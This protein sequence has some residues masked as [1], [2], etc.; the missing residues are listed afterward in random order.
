MGGVAEVSFSPPAQRVMSNLVFLSAR[1]HAYK[2]YAEA[3]S[4]HLFRRLQKMGTLHCMPTL[5]PGRMSSSA[6]AMLGGAVMLF[7]RF[8][9]TCL[10]IFFLAAFAIYRS[11]VHPITVISMLLLSAYVYG[12]FSTRRHRNA[13]EVWRPVG[14]DKVSNFLQYRRLYGE[15][16]AVFFGDNGQGDL[17]CGEQLARTTKEAAA[18]G[19]GL[20]CI[21]GVFIHEVLQQSM[22]LTS[23][24]ELSEEARCEEWRRLNIHFHR[25]YLGAAINTYNC[26]LISREG[27]ARVGNAAV[28]DLIR[29]RLHCLSAK[30]DWNG[31][32]EDLNGDVERA[33]A[34]LTEDQRITPVPQSARQTG[35]QLLITP[36]LTEFIFSTAR[37]KPVRR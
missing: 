2:D 14:E 27:L 21:S 26:G 9:I 6:G 25:T 17:L 16:S 18:N 24:E 11:V 3:K 8:F 37:P 36:S 34:L 30:C 20:P 22:Q 10:P 33:N 12:E 13:S 29:M 4:Y 15:C 5:L 1:P 28:E 35:K 31:L 23:L 32:I 19:A 7:R